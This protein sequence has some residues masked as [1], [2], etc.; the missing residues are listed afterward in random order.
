MRIADAWGENL[1]S[2]RPGFR[3]TFDKL[4]DRGRSAVLSGSHYRDS[5]P[6]EGGRWGLSVVLRPDDAIADSLAALTGQVL[7]VTGGG[8]WPTGNPES[9]HF[10]VRALDVHRVAATVVDPLVRRCALALKR[11]AVSCRPI[12]LRLGGLTL[13]PSGVMLC[14]YPTDS[15]AGEF[16]ARLEAELGPD[17]WFEQDFDRTIWYST[18]VHFTG[19]IPDP[20]GLVDWVATRRALDVGEVTMRQADLVRFRFNG[21]QPVCRH[22][23]GARLD[24][25]P[26]D[27]PRARWPL[28]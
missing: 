23:V 22:L 24:A 21:W 2:A 10:T 6:V 16:A 27:V 17:S 15:A 11:A 19:P 8:H 25:V 4:F 28:V 26:V 9:V 1:E 3:R 18:L 20:A 5:P 13:T 7:T 14:A 12:R